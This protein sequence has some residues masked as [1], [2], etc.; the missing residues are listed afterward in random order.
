VTIP[1]TKRPNWCGSP[2]ASVY[3]K[4]LGAKWETYSCEMGRAQ[5][6]ALDTAQ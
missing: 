1:P 2:A 5:Q 6:R 4:Q 3:F